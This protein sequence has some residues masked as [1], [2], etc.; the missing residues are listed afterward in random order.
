ME[1]K[2]KQRLS[3]L[4]P[5]IPLGP[6]FTLSTHE[7]TLPGAER[8]PKRSPGSVRTSCRSLAPPS[9][10]CAG[11][12]RP[13]RNSFSF[14]A[15]V[16][17]LPRLISVY[18]RLTSLYS[19]LSTPCFLGGAGHITLCSAPS[20]CRRWKA[21]PPHTPARAGTGGSPGG[22]VAAPGG[23]GHVRHE[24]EQG[25]WGKDPG[26]PSRAQTRWQAVELGRVPVRWRGG[27]TASPHVDSGSRAICVR[28]S[29]AR[30]GSFPKCPGEALLCLEA[31]F[32]IIQVRVKSLPREPYSNWSAPLIWR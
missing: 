11:S 17:G 20:G 29:S 25:G 32:Q 18:Q 22:M 4:K 8:G 31:W 16:Q 21:V 10:L 9:E 23:R 3:Q 28:C 26:P 14:P 15:D 5:L 30:H 13:R 6:E 1:T 27:S 12:P 19:I 2:W 7:E 24:G